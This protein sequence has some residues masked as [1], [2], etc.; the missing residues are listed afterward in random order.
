METMGAPS[1]FVRSQIPVVVLA[2]PSISA[3]R[4]APP[5]ASSTLLLAPFDLASS[6][7]YPPARCCCDSPRPVLVFRC[8]STTRAPLSRPPPSVTTLLADIETTAN[9][10]RDS[11]LPDY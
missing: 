4:L 2:W 5:V 9:D 7:K 11:C 10:S 8:F 6:V 3:F 1:G